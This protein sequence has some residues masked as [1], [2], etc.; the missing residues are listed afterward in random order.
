ME[1]DYDSTYEDNR[2][3][4]RGVLNVR[5]RIEARCNVC[6]DE[7]A[8]ERENGEVKT[9]CQNKKCSI[10]RDNE[11]YFDVFDALRGVYNEILRNKYGR[12]SEFYE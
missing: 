9:R 12:G 5:N 3:T 8:G 11:L 7:R 10:N 1:L 4:I 6:N 2:I